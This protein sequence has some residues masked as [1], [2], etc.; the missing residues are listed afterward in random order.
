[1]STVHSVVSVDIG[2]VHGHSVSV[3]IG[4]VHSHS[5]CV[6]ISDNDG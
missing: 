4:D 3:D 2:D 1:M 6:C 5:A